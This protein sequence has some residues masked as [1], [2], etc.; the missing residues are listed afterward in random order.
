MGPGGRWIL[1]L[2]LHGPLG[3]A[4]ARKFDRLNWRYEWVTTLSDRGRAAQDGRPP[5]L[6]VAADVEPRAVTET[7]RRALVEPQLSE[8]PLE[9]V[10]GLEPEHRQ[11][12]RQ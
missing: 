3:E 7:A 2:G 1:L 9:Y 8:L 10:T 6:V 5:E 11:F 4:V 12:R